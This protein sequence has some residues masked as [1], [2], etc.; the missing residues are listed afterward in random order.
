MRSIGPLVPQRAAGPDGRLS[1]LLRASPSVV[2]QVPQFRPQAGP[3]PGEDPSPWIED[4]V[5]P[6]GKASVVQAQDLP[7]TSTDPIP[8]M[9]LAQPAG[10]CEPESCTRRATGGN[11][12]NER[13]G[14]TL[15]PPAIH[16]AKLP[17]PLEPE[18]LR[19]RGPRSRGISSAQRKGASGLSRDV[20]SGPAGLPP[21]SCV[22]GT[23]ASSRAAG[24]SVET[25]AVAFSWN[26]SVENLKSTTRTELRSTGVSGSNNLC[27]GHPD[28]PHSRIGANVSR[29]GPDKPC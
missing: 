27:A 17:G 20:A 6:A 22:A 13:R 9:R 28:P 11:K 26:R 29:P 7:D 14:D 24:C 19:K 5:L 2:E 3:I 16:A 12:G 18:R 21:S 10:R 1:E 15:L 23:H 25:F 8:L 4:D